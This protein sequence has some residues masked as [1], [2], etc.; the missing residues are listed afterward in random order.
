MKQVKNCV[1]LLAVLL[2]LCAFLPLCAIADADFTAELHV[3]QTSMP[4]EEGEVKLRISVQNITSTTGINCAVYKLY[5]DPEAVELISWENHY[6]A[7]WNI[8]DDENNALAEDWACIVQNTNE[9]YFLYTVLN[10]SLD[11]GVKEDDV[12]YTDFT[13]RVRKEGDQSI[14][15]K[16]ISF[17]K[18]SLEYYNAPDQTVPLIQTVA[19]T[20]RSNTEENVRFVNVLVTIEQ[21]RAEQ[22][23]T[24]FEFAMQYDQ[25]VLRLI[26]AEP[27]APASW[28]K[29]DVSMTTV[30]HPD[31]AIFS[32]DASEGIQIS[33]NQTLG[34]RLEF[35][36]RN[37]D[38]SERMVKIFDTKLVDKQGTEL[39][40]SDYRIQVR[41]DG[42]GFWESNENEGKSLKILIAVLVAVVLAGAAVGTWVFMRKKKRI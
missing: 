26:K 34:I 19:P 3:S 28:N 5:Y 31:T 13:F 29:D 7:D 12:L 30:Y 9:T 42:N 2:V 33:E 25:S 20:D 40:A 41:Y 4:T 39:K 37:A 27:I 1:F 18:P 35:E 23:I 22:G 38:F 10:L 21:A 24:N 8:S 6:P 32:I 11:D 36:I 16:E 14:Q 15:L 17:A